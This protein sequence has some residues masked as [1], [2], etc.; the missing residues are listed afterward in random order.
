MNQRNNNLQYAA[1]AIAIAFAL[2]GVYRYGADVY[3]HNYQLQSLLSTNDSITSISTE[4]LAEL[5][6]QAGTA[7]RLRQERDAF[8]ADILGT[9]TVSALT[10]TSPL[11]VSVIGRPPQSPYDTFVINEGATAGLKL[12]DAVWWAPGIHLGEIVTLHQK[13]ALVQLTSASSVTHPAVVSGIPVLVE[14]RGGDAMQADL[15]VSFDVPVGSV[16]FSEKYDI[17]IGV[18]VSVS[19]LPKTDQQ[20]LYIVRHVSSSVIK[21]VYVQQ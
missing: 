12:G 1:L 4:Q 9:T 11:E 17:P 6:A 8:R 19:A 21:N 13:S 2:F 7:E 5:Q 16:V 18:V 3:V 15:P 14:G 10:Q 20:R